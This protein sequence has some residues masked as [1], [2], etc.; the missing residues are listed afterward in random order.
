MESGLVQR[1]SQTVTLAPQLRQGLKL[2]SLNLP[3]LRSDIFGVI[4][5]VKSWCYY[6]IQI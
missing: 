5:C 2:L 3:D 4:I 1:Q 6:I